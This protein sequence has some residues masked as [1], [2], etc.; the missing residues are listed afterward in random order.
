VRVDLQQ[1]EDDPRILAQTVDAR[2][3]CDTGT[4]WPWSQ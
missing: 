1:R 2:L 3:Q 4:A